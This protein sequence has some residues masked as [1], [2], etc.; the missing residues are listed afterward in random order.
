M[1]DTLVILHNS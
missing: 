1:R